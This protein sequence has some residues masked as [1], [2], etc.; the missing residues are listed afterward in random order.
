MN[1]YEW[2]SKEA[3]DLWHERINGQLGYPNFET[4]TLVYTEAYEVD[5]KWISYVDDIYA[6]GLNITQ[7]RLIENILA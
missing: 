5:G 2:D 4:N 6:E 7:L 1:W 3:F